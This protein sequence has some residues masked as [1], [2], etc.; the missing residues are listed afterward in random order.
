ECGGMDPGGFPSPGGGSVPTVPAE[1]SPRRRGFF[2]REHGGGRPAGEKPSGQGVGG[3]RDPD[4]GGAV[5]PACAG[6]G[7]PGSSEQFHPFHR[8]GQKA[9]SRR[10]PGTGPSQDEPS[11]HA[12]FRLSRG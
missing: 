3:H 1:T 2:R 11:G 8:R 4:G 5:R 7:C 10:T 12:P 6:G 9:A